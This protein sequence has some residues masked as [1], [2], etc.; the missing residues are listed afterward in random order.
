MSDKVQDRKDQGSWKALFS[1]TTQV[2]N[3]SGE[4]T[5][6]FKLPSKSGVIDPVLFWFYVDLLRACWLPG[7]KVGVT[8]ISP[9]GS[10]RKSK[11]SLVLYA[12]DKRS[13]IKRCYLSAHGKS[14]GTL[15]EYAAEFNIR[16]LIAGKFGREFEREA[17]D[18]IENQLQ[19]VDPFTWKLKREKVLF[20]HLQEWKQSHLI[21]RI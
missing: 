5:H 12:L 18:E 10:I 13:G 20:R 1:L 14:W 8:K 6:C 19:Y 2:R 3:K 21:D 17:V 11:P 9:L 7:N 16:K 4:I 15:M